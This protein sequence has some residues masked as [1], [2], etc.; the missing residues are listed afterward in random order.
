MLSEHHTSDDGYLPSPIPVAAA[1]AAV[2]QRIPITICALLVNFYDPLRLA[3]DLAVLDH[4]SEGRVSH[5]IGLGYRPEEYALFGRPMA[6]RGRDLEARIE[7]LLQAWTGEEFDLRGPAR[8][9]DPDAVHAAAPV[10]L[11][12]R[13]HRRGRPAGGA[14]RACTSSRSTATPRSRSA[15]DAACRAAGREPGFTM[16]APPGPANVFCAEDPD[17]VLGAA[18]PAPAR[19]RGGLPGV[20]RHRGVLRR[21]HLAHRRGDAGGRGLRR[22]H[23]RRPRRPVPL[24]R[25]PAGHL[26]PRLRRAA[27][28]AVVGA[29][30]AGQ[31]AGHARRVRGPASAADQRD[32]P[33]ELDGG[34]DVGDRRPRR[35]RGEA[36]P[37][38]R[39]DR[40]E[41]PRSTPS[42][43]PDAASMRRLPVAPYHSRRS[44]SSP[45]VRTPLSTPRATTSVSAHHHGAVATCVRY[46]AQQPAEG[47]HPADREVEPERV[48]AD[49]P[50]V[51]PDLT[52]KRSTRI[53]SNS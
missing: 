3:E 22:A 42:K 40:R 36:E 9:G 5:T 33:V 44:R 10:P 24:G 14:A 7:V 2:T 13:R 53:S 46:D 34:H 41:A 16:L 8:A 39:V 50:P 31:R 29:P 20:A 26:A 48:G 35:G 4:L 23:A 38:R 11:L 25:D 21:R 15:Y 49:P 30:P 19:R 45:R 47:R 52:S 51:R 17:R 1:M 18:R 12:R 43:L 32:R 6:T 28:G 37:R 27:R